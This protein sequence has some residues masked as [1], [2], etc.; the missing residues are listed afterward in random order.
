M[1]FQTPLEKKI[2][3]C[4]FWNEV[5]IFRILAF[6]YYYVFILFFCFVFASLI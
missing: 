3:N 6:N 1:K 2:I 4:T 5:D